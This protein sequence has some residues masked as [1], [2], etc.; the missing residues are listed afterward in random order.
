MTHLGTVPCSYT[1]QVI[2]LYCDALGA[3]QKIPISADTLQA[4]APFL[5][6]AFV[7]IP[8]P[9]YGPLAF[10]EFWKHIQPSLAHL[11]GAYPEE[12]KSALK[13]SHDVLGI[14]VPIGIF[15]GTESYTDG[16]SLAWVCI[17][18]ATLYSVGAQTDGRAR[19]RRPLPSLLLGNC[20]LPDEPVKQ[21]ISVQGD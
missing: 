16:R 15:L 4:F 6:S 8:E 2:P 21:A 11:N 5:C 12:I 1:P 3:L 17:V 7:R 10:C 14:D 19:N 13:A 18:S 9:G 20:R